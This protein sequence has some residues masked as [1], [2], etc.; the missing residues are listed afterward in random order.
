[1]TDMNNGGGNVI[2]V[3]VKGLVIENE[4]SSVRYMSN[5]F[6]VFIT[7]LASVQ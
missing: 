3:S 1:M 5:A 6:A 2:M 4:K 7:R